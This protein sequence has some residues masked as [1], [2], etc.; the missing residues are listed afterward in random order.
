VAHLLAVTAAFG[1]LAASGMVSFLVLYAVEQDLSPAAAGLVL[2][3]SSLA[4]GLARAG[5]G[6]LADRRPGRALDLVVCLL[7]L[8]ALGFGLLA[9]GEPA[10]IVAGAIVAGG[11]G[12][13][14]SG[15]MVLALVEKNS[16]SPGWAVGVGMSGVFVGAAIGPLLTGLIANAASFQAAWLVGA[17]FTL[18]AAAVALSARRLDRR[19]V[20]ARL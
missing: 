14:W 15:L 5:F 10:A 20:S 16:K 2:A 13:G 19:S 4:A 7:T 17:G 1:N 18:A 8:G 11:V 6:A 3:V 12:W 9:T